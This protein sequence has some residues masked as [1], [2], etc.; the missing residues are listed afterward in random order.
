[1]RVCGDGHCWSRTRDLSCVQR[2]NLASTARNG[3][4]F[5][6]WGQ[7]VPA[8]DTSRQTVSL[9]FDCSSEDLSGLLLKFAPVGCLLREA[10]PARGGKSLH[11]GF[12]VA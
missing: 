7:R 12:E 3:A 4:I 2:A 8:P 9:L 1:M 10:S 5:A 11:P 6:L